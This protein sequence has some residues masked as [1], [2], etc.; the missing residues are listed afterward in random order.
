MLDES[1]RAAVRQAALGI[2]LEAGYFEDVP[3]LID[4]AHE[5]SEFI[6]YGAL[7]ERNTANEK[8]GV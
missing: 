4:A 2:A 1:Q 7:R 8:G 3:R 5:V 6:L